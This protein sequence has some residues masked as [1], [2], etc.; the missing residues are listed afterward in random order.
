M[1]NFGIH[2]FG[3]YAD[4]ENLFKQQVVLSR[5][6]RYPGRDLSDF[7]GNSFTVPF[8]GPRTLSPG[9]QITLGARWS[10]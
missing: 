8:G 10:F 2:R 4:I 7:E 9:R 1:F 5:E 3:F 6:S